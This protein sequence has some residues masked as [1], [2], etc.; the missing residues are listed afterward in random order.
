MSD[1]QDCAGGGLDTVGRVPNVIHGRW[2]PETRQVQKAINEGSWTDFGT[3]ETL[4]D[5]QKKIKNLAGT[6]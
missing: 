4:E 6:H 3:A 1:W 5:A 2:N